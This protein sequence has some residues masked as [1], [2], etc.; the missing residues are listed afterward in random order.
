MNMPRRD[1]PALRALAA[2]ALVVFAVRCNEAPRASAPPGDASRLTFLAVG[3][4]G[5]GGA[6]GQREVASAMADY[7]D[8]TPVRFVLSTG[9]NFYENGV[10]SVGDPEWRRSFEEIYA[11]PSLQVPWYVALGNHD[12]HGNVA[13][14]IAYAKTSTRW[15]M[16][17]RYYTATESAGSRT[18]VQIF[19]LDTCP[20]IDEYRSPGSITKVQDQDPAKQLAWLEKELAGSTE[21]WKVVFGHHAVYSVGDHGDSAELIRDVKP[22]LEK[23]GVQAYV[24]GHDH[25]LQV[26]REGTVVYFTSGAGSSTTSVK[27]TP[28]T[29]FAEAVS[30]FMAFTLADDR[31]NVDVRDSADRTIHETVV[32]R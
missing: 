31:I 15:R 4:W 3:D 10:T 1:N 32:R 27:P 21:P 25:S 28:R 12:Y 26:R 7:A 9:D 19:C 17:D 20:F 11:R 8:R 5:R 24:N 23:Y 18:R 2:A 30:G 14:Q 29:E 6:A 22:L 16:P 13:V